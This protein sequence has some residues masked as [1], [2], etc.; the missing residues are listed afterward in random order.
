MHDAME[1]AA[2]NLEGP[3]KTAYVSESSSCEKESRKR[4]QKSHE[5]AHK[6]RRQRRQ[7]LSQRLPV[8]RLSR[9]CEARL[10]W[11]GQYVESAGSSC[12]PSGP[13]PRK[14][15]AQQLAA[16]STLSMS[17]QRP[18]CCLRYVSTSMLLSGTLLARSL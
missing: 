13:T 18:A 11:H 16:A 9:P 3:S 15:G 4:A 6:M 5:R 7:R 10:K 1:F 2:T 12:C 14:L 17:W 8:K